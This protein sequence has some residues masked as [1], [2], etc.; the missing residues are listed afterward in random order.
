VLAH[1]QAVLA[2]RVLNHDS[3]TGLVC[4]LVQPWK[5]GLRWIDLVL[6]SL[7]KSSSGMQMP[8]YDFKQSK[9]VGY[10]AVDVP[11][12]RVVVIEGIYALSSRIR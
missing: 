12:S 6:Y 1:L 4:L 8:I 9:R 3:V 10:K 5:V 7:L 2:S 11:K